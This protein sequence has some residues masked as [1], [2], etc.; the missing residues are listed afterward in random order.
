MATKNLTPQLLD[1]RVL[2][3]NV[4]DG[5]LSADDLK[6]H[7][8]ALPDVTGKGEPLRAARPGLDEDALDDETEE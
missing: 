8:A 6:A 7:L 2:Q 3:R 1:T 5:L 4:Q